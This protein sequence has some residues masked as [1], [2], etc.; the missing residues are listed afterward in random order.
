[1]GILGILFNCGQCKHSNLSTSFQRKIFA[2]R[3]LVGKRNVN[4]TDIY[5]VKIKVP[6]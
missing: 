3:F 1:M 6:A 4:D 2:I 5:N